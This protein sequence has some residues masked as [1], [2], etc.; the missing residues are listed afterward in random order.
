MFGQEGQELQRIALVG[1]G[2]LRRHP[3]FGGKMRQPAAH[4][5]RDIGREKRQIL[6]VFRVF[7]SGA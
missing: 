2:R 7:G 3:P 6:R 1:F 4:F 5:T